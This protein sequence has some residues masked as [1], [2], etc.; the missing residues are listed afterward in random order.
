VLDARQRGLDAT[1]LSDAIRAVD[2]E[3][4]DGDRAV[5]EM[6]AAAAEIV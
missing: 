2:L 3:P 6:R 1:V 4:G 5:E